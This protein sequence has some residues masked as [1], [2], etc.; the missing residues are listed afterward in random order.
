MKSKLVLRAL[1]S[2]VLAGFALG[3]AAQQVSAEKHKLVQK[4]LSLWHAEEA[5]I[6]MVQRPAARALE[7]SNIALQ[8]RVSAQKQE[9][10]MK[11]IAQDV[12]KYV[13][14]ATPIARDNALRLKETTLGPLLA[15]NFNDDELRQLVAL[16][17]SPVKKKFEQLLPG[18]ERAYGEKVAAEGHAAI[19]PKLQALTQTVG[20]KLRAAVTP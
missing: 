2:C 12:Q 19:D 9:A 16:L 15:A 20:T 17:E 5:A 11:D 3:V 14:E 1:C 8:G 7:Q 13:D 10:T 18:F 4:V 6:V